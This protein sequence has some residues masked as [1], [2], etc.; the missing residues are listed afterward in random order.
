[1][2]D[3][4]RS[5][6]RYLV[7]L[8]VFGSW[9]LALGYQE[10]RAGAVVS[11]LGLPNDFTFPGEQVGA[12]IQIGATPIG[13]TDVVFT[14][15][16]DGLAPG[17]SFAIFGRN[18]DGTV[19]H[20][21][22]SDFTLSH[23]STSGNTT[24]SANSPFTLQAGTSYWLMMLV[25]QSG[26][27]ANFGD[28]DGS[29]SLTYMSSFGVTIPDTNTSVTYLS[30]FLGNPPTYHY[31]NLTAGLQ[32]F[33]VDGSALGAVPEPS[34]LVL[35]GTAALAGLGLWARRHR[36]LSAPWGPNGAE[37]GQRFRPPRL[38]GLAQPARMP[39]G[40]TR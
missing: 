30:D 22:F 14:Q 7:I 27:P 21:L 32:L 18:A 28:W 16:D 36:A 38:T 40:T 15:L 39:T 19:G 6:R 26:V 4:H 12:A 8:V 2:I 11:T 37:A 9:A 31:N 24:A 23:D 5:V 25:Q 29:N 34:A 13:L 10:A 3:L 17:E 33:Q 1:M 35:A 20:S